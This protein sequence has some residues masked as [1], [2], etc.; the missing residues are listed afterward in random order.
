[1]LP[2]PN[3]VTKVKIEST[4]FEIYAYRKLSTSEY[5]FAIRQYLQQNRLSKVPK[6]K[7]IK[8]ITIIGS[9]E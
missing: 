4:T 9:I 3:I 6:N 2:T 5:R 1:M 8:I 7:K